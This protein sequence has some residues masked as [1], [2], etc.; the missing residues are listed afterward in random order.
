MAISI[1]ISIGGP[2]ISISI[3]ISIGASISISIWIGALRGRRRWGNRR[4]RVRPDNR[5][6]GSREGKPAGASIVVEIEIEIVG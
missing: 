3:S 4:A 5:T 2:S 6:A 1:S